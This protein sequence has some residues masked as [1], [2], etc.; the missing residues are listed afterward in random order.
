MSFDPS[1]GAISG[2]SDVALN[3][4][5]NT[6]IF[7]YN[8]TLQKWQNTS[9]TGQVSLAT[10]GGAE[11]ISTIGSATGAVTLNLANGN[12]F[13]VTLT[14]NT[15]F[16]F[17]GATAGRAC[18]LSLYLTENATGGYGV[19]WPSSVKWSGGAPTLAT[20]AGNVNILV[21]E[22]LNGGTTW[23]GSL[24]GANFA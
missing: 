1:G 20:A 18:S 16:T 17:S 22:T 2:A 24:V 11:T 9:L 12:V 21:F 8:G 19:T 13:N 10:G 3:N 23:F 4:P 5:A 14:G 7:S 6:N 15:T